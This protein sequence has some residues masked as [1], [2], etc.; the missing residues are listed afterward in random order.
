MKKIKKIVLVFLLILA[1]IIQYFHIADVFRVS[2]SGTKQL[3]IGDYLYLNPTWSSDT[4]NQSSPDIFF[5]YDYDGTTNWKY[6]LMEKCTDNNDNV[7]FRIK[8]PNDL[9]G[10]F[11]FIRA[12]KGVISNGY[13]GAWNSNYWNQTYA[14]SLSAAQANSSNTYKLTGWMNDNEK[15]SS[16]EWA[17][18]DDA[19][20]ILN[21]AG[22]TLY[23]YNTDYKSTL[24]TEVKALFYESETSAANQVQMSLVSDNLWS[25]TIPEGYDYNM[26]SFYNA[27]SE[28]LADVEIMN[29]DFDP[30]GDNTYYYNRT[31]M[32]NGNT[33]SS[34]GEK[35][36]QT[37]SIDGKKLYF[38]RFSFMVDIGTAPTIQIGNGDVITLSKDSSDSTVYSYTIPSGIGATSQTVI[39]VNYNGN[40]YNFFW[41][42][43]TY[44]CVNPVD[45]IASASQTYTSVQ[46]GMRAVYFD[47]TLSKL[48]YSDAGDYGIPK[49]SGTI[50]Y[51]AYDGSSNDSEG[52]MEKV[53][54][55][56][57]DGNT[58]SDVYVAYVPQ[59]CTKIAFSNF[60]MSSATNYGGHGESTEQVDIPT[61]ISSPCFYA[62]TS[63]TYI[64]DGGTRKGYW[65][66]IGEIRNPETE[67]T[68]KGNEVVNI[69][70]A[71]QTRDLDTLYLNTTFYDYYTDYELNGNNR[72]DYNFSGLSH[73]LYQ[74]FRQ[75]NQALSSY[76]S[77][78]RAQA[79]LYWGNFQNYTGENSYHFNEISG[80]LNLYGSDNPNEFFYMNNSGWGRN[81]DA[82][83]IFTA[84]TQGLVSDT[85]VNGNLMIECGNS[86]T[87]NA[88]YFDDDFIQGENSKNTILGKVYE[89]VSFPFKKK[90]ISSKSAS[91]VSG[92]VEYWYFDSKETDN[93]LRLKKDSTTGSYFLNP[94]S[95]QVHG[96][97]TSQGNAVSTS[98][99][100]FFPFNG[101]GQNANAGKLN[102]GFGTR[103]DL[104]FRL[105]ENGTVVNSDS[106]EVPI[107]FNFSGD[108]DIWI[109]IDGKLALDLGGDH[110]AATGYLNFEDKTWHVEYV[111]NSNS[112]GTTEKD[113]AIGNFSL[114]GSNTDEH[115]LTLFYMERGLWE[116]NMYMSFNFPDA[117]YFEVEKQI[118]ES[119]V[120]Q[121]LFSGLFDN[122]SFEF[123][124]RNLATHFGT[125][126]VTS[127]DEIL[128]GF[129]TPQYQIPDYGSATSGQLEYPEGAKYK[130]DKND[131]TSENGT[132]DETGKFNLYNHDNI[133]FVDQFRRGSYISVREKTDELFTTSYTMYED[134]E[135]V[136]YMSD[137]DTVNLGAGGVATSLAGVTGPN[138]DDGRIEVYQTGTVD[139]VVVSNSGYTSTAKP[140]DN[141]IVFRSYLSPDS[142]TINTRLKVIYTNKVKTGS[143]RI[144]KDRAYDTDVLN[145]DY[146]FTI[147]FEDVG[148]QNLEGDSIIQKTV[149][150]KYGETVEIAGIPIN[151]KYTITEVVSDESKLCEVVESTDK[152]FEYDIGTGLTSGM[153][154]E[155]GEVFDFIFKNTLKPLKNVIVI[156]RWQDTIGNSL[157][158]N[159][160]E[161]VTVQLQ[162]RQGDNEFVKVDEAQDVILS[163]SNGWTYTFANL[164]KYVDYTVNPL[165][166]WEYRVVEIKDDVVIENDGL[167]G[168]YKVTY[169]QTDTEGALIQTIINTYIPRTIIKV[170]K[171]DATN[172]D[173]KLEGVEFKLEKLNDDD[174][175]DT[176]FTEIIQ[177][178]D[179]LG[180]TEFINLK[181]GRYR[182]TET[183]TNE[184]YILL[185]EPITIV[186][187]RTGGDS[188]INGEVC[189]VDDDSITVNVANSKKF[190][191]PA[192]GGYGST[193]Y[194]MAGFILIWMAGFTYKIL[195]LR[196]KKL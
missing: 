93:N 120:N 112:S 178:T 85:L 162:R 167:S 109:F 99:V 89:N 119:N 181:E 25:V 133:L 137:G 179:V 154:N 46:S 81:G 52:N 140:N 76:Y 187:N 4:W 78:F 139:G 36:T 123:D 129:I 136:T 166:E 44:N 55:F 171:S 142:E 16:G 35:I 182:L 80:D 49:K 28:L 62:D 94:S 117:N 97:V 90:A 127:S 11:Q 146:T 116:S 147:T 113:K 51:Y 82:L 106:N 165:V 39:T 31:I 10:N 169:N 124:I 101:S 91:G 96:T 56:T 174:T 189:T 87:V 149:V 138:V 190:V 27:N 83:S 3:A 130:I 50:R 21:H 188:T 54:E 95:D 180:V 77:S 29:G 177:A 59:A 64:Y 108:D 6:L 110:G 72:D 184:E 114:E 143:I 33:I 43:L 8:I 163:A 135:A 111:K 164:D 193:I 156:K 5:R 148:G 103:F 79:P 68:I 66:G 67:A 74:P 170:V 98:D 69:L 84:A 40:T 194:F 172:P 23:F 131:G 60:D 195:R 196:R 118:D 57:I 141:T 92:T 42:D 15:H 71:T 104:N 159:L 22:E 24:I 17:T 13:A 107:E 176:T 75:F 192:T 34:F 132:I 157:T 175:V 150:L 37:T 53:P 7:L 173:L 122:Y 30:G 145:G 45:N 105:T 144:T 41:T 70:E 20:T 1:L 63:D 100:N 47:A 168:D 86:G 186:I 128:T 38:N 185:K 125:K 58:Y 26:V 61:D 153:I 152:S 134:G 151:T 161:S 9:K 126:E 158:N 191:F 160:P 73:R 121:E 19:W 88:P 18:G 2:G 155:D 48:P 115:T 102:Y 14:L 65:A 32:E 12:A 183:N